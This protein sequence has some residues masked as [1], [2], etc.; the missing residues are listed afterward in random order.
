MNLDWEMSTRA[1]FQVAGWLSEFVV[2]PAA[3]ALTA[4]LGGG[5]IVCGADGE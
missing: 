5:A 1:P 3:F 2:D 4:A